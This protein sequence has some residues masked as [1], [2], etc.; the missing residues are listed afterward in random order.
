MGVALIARVFAQNYLDRGTLVEATDLTLPARQ[1]HYLVQPNARNRFRPEV[2][3]VKDWLLQGGR[4]HGLLTSPT[5]TSAAG[6][7]WDQVRRDAE[8]IIHIERQRRNLRT[9]LALGQFR[10]PR[11]GKEHQFLQGVKPVAI[12]DA[13][14][15]KPTQPL[16]KRRREGPVTTAKALVL[17]AEFGAGRGCKHHCTCAFGEVLHRIIGHHPVAPGTRMAKYQEASAH[18]G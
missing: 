15:R 11:R 18:S 10:H 1:G 16:Q 7:V 5:A 17:K 4:H 9:L 13:V 3:A 6:E 14:V 12:P 8:R 2:S